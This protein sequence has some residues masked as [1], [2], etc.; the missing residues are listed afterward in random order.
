MDDSWPP[1]TLILAMEPEPRWVSVLPPP[2]REL[3]KWPL[4]GQERQFYVW[5]R[6]SRPNRAGSRR[7]VD[8]KRARSLADQKLSMAD[9]VTFKTWHPL[10]GTWRDVDDDYG[11]RIQFTIRT[12]GEAFEVAG[13]DTSDGEQ[14]SI[15][16][17]CWDGRVLRFDSFVPSTDHRVECAFE[18]TS[19]SEVLVC[20]T[21][22]ERWVRADP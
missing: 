1:A 7:A 11:S 6:L 10:V 3:L 15:S 20:Y 19:S 12:A 2:R 8:A 21:R 14:L 13:L 9:I 4:G 16:N 22:S 17:V 18:V 5:L